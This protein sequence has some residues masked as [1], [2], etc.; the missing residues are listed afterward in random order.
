MSEGRLE[1]APGYRISR[2]VNGG[3]QLS[4]G[5]GRPFD[6]G[7]VVDDLLRLVDA[8]F[9]T[10]DCADIYTG[11]EELY[12]EMLRR[13]R[14][15]G[16]DPEPAGIQIHTKCVPDLADLAGLRRRDVEGTVDRLPAAARG[17]GPG[18]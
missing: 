9:T 4:E 11:V 17:H 18:G 12:G 10:F 6:R 1:L 2:I 16:S 8:G 15:R 3:W 5:H 7:A 13:Y 14:E